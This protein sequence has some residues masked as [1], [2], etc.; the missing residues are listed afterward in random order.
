MEGFPQKDLEFGRAA[1]VLK[2]IPNLLLSTMF[3]E[4][5]YE[6]ME[7]LEGYVVTRR[8]RIVTSLIKSPK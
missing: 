2:S 4:L 5:I 7:Q 8:N 1:K 3:K 6:R